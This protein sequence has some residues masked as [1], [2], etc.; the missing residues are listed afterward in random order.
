M[1]PDS[2]PGPAPETTIDTAKPGRRRCPQAHAAIMDAT[3][4]ILQEVGYSRLTVEGVAARAGVGKTTVYRWWHSKS[5]LVIEAI[6]G[7]LDLPPPES[8]GDS[9]ADVRAVV[10]RMA[11]TFARPPLGEVLPALAVDL[12]RDPQAAE[13]LRQMIGPRRAANAA[14]LYSVAGRGDLPH[15]I[16][17]HAVLDI[18]AGAI[19]Y[20]S[21]VR[22]AP[23]SELLDQIT[24]LVL[25][26]RLPRVPAQSLS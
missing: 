3:V 1:V 11:D 13:Q 10:Q 26:G 21:L 6:N 9:R 25:G 19:L 2:T 15:D 16:D 5:S 20:R 8:T 4:E 18:I 22:I 7:R 17:V 23:T 14:V 12:I 24:E